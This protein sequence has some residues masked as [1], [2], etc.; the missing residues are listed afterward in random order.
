MSL[1]HK[2]ATTPPPLP[3]DQPRNIDSIFAFTN[4]Y[5]G[6]EH[7]C[8]FILFTDG[9]VTFQGEITRHIAASG[10]AKSDQIDLNPITYSVRNGIIQPELLPHY[11]VIVNR[12]G[13]KIVEFDVDAQAVKFTTS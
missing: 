13:E 6:P 10:L 2:T 9:F 5:Q 1:E 12:E 11:Q 8:G 3:G 4:K 7:W